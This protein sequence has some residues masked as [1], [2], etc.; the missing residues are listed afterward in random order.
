LGG[1]VFIKWNNYR[2]LIGLDAYSVWVLLALSIATIVTE[3]FGVGIF[4]PIMQVITAD[5]DINLLISENKL[6]KYASDFFSYINV[7]LEFGVLLVLAFLLFLLRQVFTYIKLVYTATLFYSTEMHLK[8]SFFLHYLDVNGEYYDKHPIGKISN[9]MT[10]ELNSAVGAIFSPIE[11][12]TYFILLITYVAVLSALSLEMTTAVISMILIA[13][14]VPQRWISKSKVAGVKL[15]DSNIDMSTFLLSRLRSPRLVK[16]SGMSNAEINEFKSFSCAQKDRSVEARILSS[17]TEVSV[18]PVIVLLSLLFLYVSV[19][20]LSMSLEMI[21][22]YLLIS[23]RLMPIVKSIIL[24]VQKIKISLGPMVIINDSYNELI[25]NKEIDTGPLTLGK[26]VSSIVFK[27]VNFSYDQSSKNTLKGLEFS[28][29]ANELI[30]IT[31]PS[32]SGKST[33]IDMLPRLRS[34][35]SGS[36]S[37]NGKN[38]KMYSIESLRNQIAYAPQDPQ[39]FQG[40]IKEHILY[41]RSG[42]T[43]IE[44]YDASAL[45]GADTFI[46][47]LP[48]GYQTLLG[49]NGIKLSGGQRQRLDLARVLIKKSPIII[50]DEPTSNLDVES[51]KIFQESVLKVKNNTKSII[52]VISHALKESGNY[53][54]ILVLKDGYIEGFGSHDELIEK[55]DWY[56]KVCNL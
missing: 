20:F 3:A 53:D 55:S 23:I 47:D 5:G 37:I 27:N 46:K 41:G 2:K 9:I 22:L 54:K 56:S 7:D 10:E 35:Q 44:V 6:W 49:E 50:M 33:L 34:P 26:E 15:V 12:I 30:V 29:Y 11:L 39:M 38:I 52:I 1:T 25:N 19:T 18:E 42:A 51:K 45:S 32:G 21:G 31:G 48:N 13:V 36:I 43:D 4:Y 14:M 24:Q 17:R 40:T 28:I 16:L 8:N